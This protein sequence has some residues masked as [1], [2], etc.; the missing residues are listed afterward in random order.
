MKSRNKTMK[1]LVCVVLSLIICAAVFTACGEKPKEGHKVL[2]RDDNKSKEVTAVLFDTNG[3]KT[4]VDAEQV[5]KDSESVTYA[6]YGDTKKYN[7]IVFNCDGDDTDE[8]AF[9]DLVSGWHKTLNGI[10]PYTEGKK[11][12]DVI[13][14][15]VKTFDYDGNEKEV[16]ICTPDG[17]DK[18]SKEKYPV[19]Y[20]TDGG[21]LFERNA[22]TYGSWGVYESVKSM[23]KNTGTGAVIVGIDNPSATRDSE[24]TPD[25]GDVT[26]EPEIYENGK[27]KEFSDFVVNTVVPYVEKN[28]NVATE[29]ENV[30]ICGSSSGG[31]ESFY[32]GMEHAEKFGAIGALSPAFVLYD[33]NTWVKYLKTKKFDD[34]YPKVYLYCGEAN[35]LESQL[36][37][38]TRSMPGNLANISYPK[39][40][41][42][43]TY[44]NKGMHNERYWRY[45]FPDFLNFFRK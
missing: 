2:F 20:M 34:N 6:V 13:D 3:K 39:D 15:A 10:Y 1:R 38:S 40:K 18:N 31:I 36:L 5:S 37:P 32:I 12:V 44:C 41:I 8:L 35:D 27:G 7:K 23:E 19:I 24:L 29:P 9:N 28:Y 11:E 26:S 14:Y 33:D 4:P 43:E 42:Y 16:Y 21:N 25:I 22:T 45:I 30:A 17:Y